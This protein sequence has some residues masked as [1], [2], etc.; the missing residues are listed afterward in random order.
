MT[1]NLLFESSSSVVIGAA[2]T[3]QQGKA[4]CQ[5]ARAAR[6]VAGG[7]HWHW[8]PAGRRGSSSFLQIA[9][10]G[11]MRR[12]WPHCDRA[13]VVVRPTSCAGVGQARPGHGGGGRHAGPSQV[14]R[15]KPGPGP[16]SPGGHE[17]ARA[18][19]VLNPAT[20]EHATRRSGSG[21]A[22]GRLVRYPKSEAMG[23]KFKFELTR[24]AFALPGHPVP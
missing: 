3:Y 16:F 7:R 11:S 12:F 2:S 5:C 19:A 1:L 14:A 8:P 18:T 24:V 4:H 6:V 20:P 13:T 9:L 15:P 23:A 22:T 21:Q 17:A 10:A